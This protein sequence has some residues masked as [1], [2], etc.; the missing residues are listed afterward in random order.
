MYLGVMGA[1]FTVNACVKRGSWRSLVVQP[2]NTTARKEAADESTR[3]QFTYVQTH[4]PQSN[5]LC[6]PEIHGVLLAPLEAVVAQLLEVFSQRQRRL[7]FVRQVLESFYHARVHFLF[8]PHYC[9]GGLIHKV[10]Q[11]CGVCVCNSLFGRDRPAVRG[12]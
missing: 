5:L 7:V 1:Y 6:V 4:E 8:S 2:Y 9:F 3:T 10:Q 12:F 11:S